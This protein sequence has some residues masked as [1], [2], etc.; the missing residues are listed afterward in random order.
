MINETGPHSAQTPVAKREKRF[1]ARSALLPMR[2]GLPAPLEG[3]KFDRQ[4]PASGKC[5]FKVALAGQRENYR[6]PS[7]EEFELALKEGD[8]YG[9]RVCRHLMEGLENHGYKELADTS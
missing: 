4:R 8:L 3:R 2:S 5:R 6:F 9:L 1:G 7:N